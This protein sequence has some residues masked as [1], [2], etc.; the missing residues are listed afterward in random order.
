[1]YEYMYKCKYKHTVHQCEYQFETCSPLFRQLLEVLDVAQGAD[2]DPLIGAG[3]HVVRGEDS[4]WFERRGAGDPSREYEACRLCPRLVL[5]LIL[6][7]ILILIIL[8]KLMRI[9]T[10][11]SIRILLLTLRYGSLC[12]YTCMMYIHLRVYNS[13][14]S[15]STRAS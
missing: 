14:A 9:L 2:I 6:M 8:I 5:I 1:M 11:I 12:L 3:R 10:S 7:L 13:C 15:L 4:T